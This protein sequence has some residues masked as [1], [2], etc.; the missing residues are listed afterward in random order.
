MPV[1]TNVRPSSASE[2][3]GTGD[4]AEALA[5]AGGGDAGTAD[6]P[7]T[8]TD[9]VAPP[10]HAT[11]TTARAAPNSRPGRRVWRMWD[12]LERDG[13]CGGAG[14]PDDTRPRSVPL[15]PCSKRQST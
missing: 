12:P 4:A 11:A 14:A 10:E 5:E 7:L 8:F 13:G 9:D 3:A 6:P 15:R 1:D 2:V